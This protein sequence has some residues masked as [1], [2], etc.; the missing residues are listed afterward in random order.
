MELLTPEHVQAFRERFALGSQEGR[1]QEAI[2]V[3]KFF[4]PTSRYTLYVTEGT[5]TTSGDWTFFGYALSGLG[6]DCDEWGYTQLS[7]LKEV[8]RDGLG[9]ERDMYV[10]VAEKQLKDLLPR[11]G[12]PESE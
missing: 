5:E 4:H 8:C 10:P 7:E 1:G 9:V 12:S 2:V 11:C 3:V 6:A